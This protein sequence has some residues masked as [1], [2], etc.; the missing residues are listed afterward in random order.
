[1]VGFV[2]IPGTDAVKPEENSEGM[3]E[4][5]GLIEKIK[6]GDYYGKGN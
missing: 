5:D 3:A 1:M 2:G 4:V 6:T